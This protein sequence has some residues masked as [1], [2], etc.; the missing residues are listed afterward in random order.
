MLKSVRRMLVAPALVT[1]LDGDL[2]AVCS[3]LCKGWGGTFEDEIYV[4]ATDTL[5]YSDAV[6]GE[7]SEGS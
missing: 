5:G 6:Q 1:M 3:F 4:R 7:Y 2:L